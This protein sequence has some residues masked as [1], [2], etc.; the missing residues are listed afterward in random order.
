MNDDIIIS[1]NRCNFD[2]ADTEKKKMKATTNAC[3][4]APHTT[5]F[6]HTDT[7]YATLVHIHRVFFVDRHYSSI[8]H[9]CTNRVVSFSRNMINEYTICTFLVGFVF[10]LHSI[11]A[12]T[13]MIRTYRYEA[14]ALDLQ[15]RFPFS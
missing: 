11:R 12:S 14:D 10:E 1:P 15:R 3:K 9:L 7:A 4:Y 2:R 13:T 6:K 8:L 5:D